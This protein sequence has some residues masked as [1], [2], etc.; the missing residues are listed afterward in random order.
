MK[1]AY[2][3][4]GILTLAV[5]GTYSLLACNTS[6]PIAADEQPVDLNTAPAKQTNNHDGKISAAD[7]SKMIAGEKLT[8]VDFY[9][10]WCG[11]CKM[12]APDVV[13][14]RKEKED[15]V[16]VLQI[17]AEAQED[18]AGNY[19]IAAYPT[20]MFFKKGQVVQTLVGLQT[21]D[22][23]LLHVNKLK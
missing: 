6:S 11:P 7:F 2:I 14:L 23:L 10:T 12:M 20:I 13:K 9:T 15:L 17:D 8:M 19:N 4:V 21:Y 16:N 3:T 22:Q 1:K 18:I 5:I